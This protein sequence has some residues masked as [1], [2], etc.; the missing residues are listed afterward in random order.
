MSK[1]QIKLAAV[2]F[3]GSAAVSAEEP[4]S[5]S[6]SDYMFVRV[7]DS[8]GWTNIVEVDCISGKCELVHVH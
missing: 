6:S 5:G 1:H 3:I 2:E 8:Y 4:Y 7:A